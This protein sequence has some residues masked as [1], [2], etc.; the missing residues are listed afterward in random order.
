MKCLCDPSVFPDWTEK[1]AKAFYSFS[2]KQECLCFLSSSKVVDEQDIKLR[3]Q[4]LL[5]TDVSMAFLF[6]VSCL[7]AWLRLS[8]RR[9]SPVVC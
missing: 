5:E 7:K 6:Q 8:D 2:Q 3:M 4:M 1:I 9:D